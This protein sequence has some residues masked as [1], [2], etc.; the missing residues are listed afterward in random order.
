MFHAVNGGRDGVAWQY[1]EANLRMRA[2]AGGVWVVT[3]DNCDPADMPC[4]PS[5]G[6]VDPN[7]DWAC[8]TEP[9]GEQYYAYTVVLDP[10]ACYV[11]CTM[12]VTKRRA[13]SMAKA[14]KCSPTSVS[15]KRS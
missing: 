2:R 10:R 8:R 7:G 14:T 4:S 5:C 15:D 1:H 11:L 3:V 13:S 9:Q 12:K 6:L